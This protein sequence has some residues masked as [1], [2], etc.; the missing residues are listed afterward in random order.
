MQRPP[1]MQSLLESIEHEAGMCCS[2]NTPADDASGEGID[3]R[4]PIGSFRR[5]GALRE[6]RREDQ[7]GN[8]TVSWHGSPISWM[9]QFMSPTVAMVEAFG[10]PA[11]GRRLG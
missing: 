10:N 4:P 1:V 11:T 8:V 2:R 3:G 9:A 7:A 5:P 6:I